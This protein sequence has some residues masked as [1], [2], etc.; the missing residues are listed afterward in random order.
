MSLKPSRVVT[1]MDQEESLSLRRDAFHYGTKLGRFETSN[2]SF[3]C[4]RGSERSEQAGKRVSTAMSTSKASRAEQTNKWAERANKPMDEQ[5]AQYL[6]PDSGLFWPIEP[7]LPVFLLFQ[8]T[9]LP[10]SSFSSRMCFFFVRYCCAG[11]FCRWG[12]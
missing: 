8:L 6:R 2:H 10:L 4:K 1:V 11:G 7:C 9:E 12:C 3:S 5:V